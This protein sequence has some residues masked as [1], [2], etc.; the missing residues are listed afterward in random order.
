MCY[1]SQKI[2]CR[3]IAMSIT[4][5][6]LTEEKVKE[7]CKHAFPDKQVEVVTELMKVLCLMR[8]NLCRQR[9]RL[10][11]WYNQVEL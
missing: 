2:I 3:G 11:S 6:R 1:N 5:N 8:K 7:L 4:K 10:C 9:W